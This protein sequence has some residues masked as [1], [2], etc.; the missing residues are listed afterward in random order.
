MKTIKKGDIIKFNQESE[1]FEVKDIEYKDGYVYIS[2]TT[3]RSRLPVDDVI[4]EET[5]SVYYYK[6]GHGS[7]P[8]GKN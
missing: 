4:P 6:I 3:T 7:L 2:G 1:P 5:S 8:G